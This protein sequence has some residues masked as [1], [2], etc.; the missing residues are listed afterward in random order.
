[1]FIY[2]LNLIMIIVWTIILKI[3]RVNNKHA[4]LSIL[5]LQLYLILAL[6]SPF[7]GADTNGYINQFE[8]T[9][10]FPFFDFGFSRY[11]P[12]YLLLNKALFFIE[13]HQFFIAV[14]AF[15]PLFLIFKFISKESELVWLSVFLFIT[16]GF[17]TDTF[18][19]FRQI[20][21]MALVATSYTY[22]KKSEAKMF[23][24]LVLSAA[25]FH[26]TALSFLPIYF[27]RQINL[28]LKV[29]IYYFFIAILTFLF[30]KPIIRFTIGLFS[31]LER[32]IKGGGGLNLLI[33]LV[34]ILLIGLY[35]KDNFLSKDP[36]NVILY[37]I[38]FF[39]VIFQIIALDFAL[40]T[41][42]TRYFSLF[43]IVFIPNIIVAERNKNLVV[44][45]IYVLCC[46]TAYFY[47]NSLSTDL[48]SIVPYEFFW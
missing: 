43:V 17:Y 7:V 42:V 10:T 27:F 47:L 44:L 14:M 3:F 37:H 9:K 6:R 41:R 18:N 22:I 20:I 26:I 21:A 46:F 13:N 25:L 15:I 40:F 8:R 2:W 28:N 48:S 16:L 5:F 1:M 45:G 33:I 34:F 32:E 36:R 35:F 19:L 24:L 4:L 38:L 23:F 39:G 29:V 12:G 30:S 31:P 11:E